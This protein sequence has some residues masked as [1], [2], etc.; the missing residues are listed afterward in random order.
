MAAVK[1]TVDAVAALE[2]YEH[3]FV[4]DIETGVRAQGPERRHRPLHLG[5][6][7]RAGVDAGLAAGGLRA[8]AGDGRARPGPRSTTRTID[9][10]DCYYYA[11]PKKKD[12]PKS[13]DE[14]DPELLADLREAR[15]PAARA[16]GAGRRRG[17]A[18]LRRGRGVR[19]R[20][21]G[22]HLQEGTG[23][24]RGD[25]LL[26][27]A[28]RSASIRSWC[29]STWA[30]WCRSRDNYFA[31]LNSAVFS[32]GSLRLCPAGRALPDGAV[33][34]FPHQ[35]REDR[36]VRAHPDHRRQG[37]LRLLPGGLH[38]PD[39]RRE[40]AARRRGRAGRPGRRRDQ[41]FHRPELVPGRRR[42]QGRHL[43]LRHQARR[44]PR[45]PLQGVSW[46]QV[47]TGS[48]ITWKYPSCILRG[49]GSVGRV[50]LDRHHQRPPAGRHRHQDDP[51][52]AR[53]PLADHLQGHLG[54]ASRP[55]P[56]AAWSRPTPRPRARATSPSATAC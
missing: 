24:G 56:I 1:E 43:Q 9:Y 44:L 41:I 38:R 14:V 42:G 10:Q 20:L 53:H 26:D 17:R 50:L 35:R 31:C 23:R 3:G 52:G 6:E 27:V 18:A 19:Q 30:R 4:T 55:T 48:A 36:P 51:P 11:A 45:R 22:H 39:A 33:D 15:H 29:G 28:R 25:L 7:G 37:R 34:L 54:R 12:G 40:P 47:E 49:R 8:L 16:G 46:T 21:R 32:D 2:K 5:Q 13:L